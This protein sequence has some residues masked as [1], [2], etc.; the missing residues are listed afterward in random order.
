MAG[1]TCQPTGSQSGSL[2]RPKEHSAIQLGSGADTT[3]GKSMENYKNTKE[4]D[5]QRLRLAEKKSKG[6]RW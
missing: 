1:S 3:S 6:G 5:E 4:A 2:G